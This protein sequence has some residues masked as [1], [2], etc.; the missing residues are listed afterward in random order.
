M[1]LALLMTSSSIALLPV[2]RD[3]VEERGTEL[4]SAGTV[5]AS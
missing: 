3:I 1:S 2:V 4:R 5:V